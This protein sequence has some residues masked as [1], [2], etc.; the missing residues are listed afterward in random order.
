MNR[1]TLYSVLI[2][3][4]TGTVTCILTGITFFGLEVFETK[5][6]FFQFLVYGIIGSISFIF[7]KLK[8]YRDALFILI[9]LFLF[10]ILWIGS[11]F[12]IT[13]LIYYLSV[14]SGL[15]IFS[16]YFFIQ[17]VTIKYARP[18]I[19]ASILALLFVVGFFTLKLI[20]ASGQGKLLPFKN[21]P[22]GFLIGLGLGI[23]VELSEYLLSR[24]E[25]LKDL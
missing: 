6:P 18:L 12:P 8:R 10:D 22:V 20:Y 14:I 7:F 13:H 23:G 3:T 4:V 16:K 5:S 17:T 15:F 1:K 21:M 25:A 9:L 19:L 2:F 11:K 24:S